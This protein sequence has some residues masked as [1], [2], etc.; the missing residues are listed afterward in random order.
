MA[1][2]LSSFFMSLIAIIAGV[3]KALVNIVSHNKYNLESDPGS[4][5][6]YLIVMIGIFIGILLAAWYVFLHLTKIFVF[7]TQRPVLSASVS[8]ALIIE[9]LGYFSGVVAPKPFQILAEIIALTALIFV[10]FFVISFFMSYVRSARKI[11]RT[12]KKKLM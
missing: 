8:L 9:F 2:G 6:G 5:I 7:Y 3:I 1:N 12:P 4:Y 11:E 10:V